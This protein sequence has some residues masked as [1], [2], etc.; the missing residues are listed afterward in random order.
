MILFMTIV[1]CTFLE[2]VD[3]N[4]KFEPFT[5]ELADMAE[6]SE[7]LE[8]PDVAPLPDDPE[9]GEMTPVVNIPPSAVGN[10]GAHAVGLP[11][12]ATVM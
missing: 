4:V 12:P 9:G 11:D 3:V 10:C 5:M 7:M 2:P 6:E 1:G 8:D